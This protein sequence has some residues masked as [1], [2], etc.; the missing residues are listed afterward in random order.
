MNIND[1]IISKWE[2][3]LSCPDIFL[4]DELSDKLYPEWKIKIRMPKR[5]LGSL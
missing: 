5:D 3:G 4:L 1:K 2:R